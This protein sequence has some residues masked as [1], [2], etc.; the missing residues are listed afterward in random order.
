MANDF[1]GKHLKTS[2]APVIGAVTF[3]SL[4]GVRV[5]RDDLRLALAGV[6]LASA[7]GRDPKPSAVLRYAIASVQKSNA[8][9]VFDRVA[10]SKTEVVFGLTMKSADQAL[11][12]AVYVHATRLRLDKV[13]GGV[14]LE[15]P[16]NPTLNAVLLRYLEFRD[17]VTTTEMGLIL[18]AAIRGKKTSTGLSG[19][20][21]RG[22][23]GGV[24]FVPAGAVA[25][26]TALAEIVDGIAGEGAMTVW[27]I[28]V[29]D[30]TMAQASNAVRSD[31][32]DR[33]AEAREE[34][35]ALLQD[36]RSDETRDPLDRRVLSRVKA[37]D[38]LRNRVSVYAEILG[39]LREG[40]L[41]QVQALES[42]LSK[43]LAGVLD[44]SDFDAPAPKSDDAD[45]DEDEID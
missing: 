6:G 35:D 8:G 21:L 34:L 14:T 5:R 37:F 18:V 11:E 15:D 32:Q 20:N 29:G 25:R 12:Q 31:F 3:W 9:F 1:V 43:R 17:Y 44:G 36:L 45:E 40:M 38:G 19:V 23:T 26:L 33:L 28:P 10:E 42:E 2:T 7:Q 30:R 39:D 4:K 22:E 27:P 13:T 41:G 24:Y 16:S